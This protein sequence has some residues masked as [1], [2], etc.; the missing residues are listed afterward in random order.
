MIL[1]NGSAVMDVHLFSRRPYKGGD[2]S[3]RECV[4]QTLRRWH[5]SRWGK[6]GG[7]RGGGS[8]LHL[9]GKDGSSL[10]LMGRFFP[11]PHR[12]SVSVWV[13]KRSNCVSSSAENITS[14]V[15]VAVLC[16][17]R[18]S[19]MKWALPERLLRTHKSSFL[20]WCICVAG[21][22]PGPTASFFFFSFVQIGGH[23]FKSIL[24]SFDHMLNLQFKGFY[25]SRAMI[26]MWPGADFWE[27]VLVLYFFPR[28][29]LGPITRSLP[30]AV[31]WRT[32]SPLY[33][34]G[35]QSEMFVQSILT[36]RF[37]VSLSS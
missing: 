22:Q 7:W 17:W 2:T 26:A 10:T 35:L 28:W 16:S 9:C 25:Q 11:H 5:Y 4:A 29:K 30:P 31:S 21:P 1:R 3:D 15:H 13:V 20:W 37:V 24:K 33:L 8:L 32:G 12:W 23:A 14:R 27:V 6:G 34:T 18:R 36:R 19:L